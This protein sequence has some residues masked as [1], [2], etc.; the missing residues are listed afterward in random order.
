MK[1]DLFSRYELK[2]SKTNRILK[3][4]AYTIVVSSII[5]A[6]I[7]GTYLTTTE[8]GY[9]YSFYA[10]EIPHPARW[11]YAFLIILGG[12]SSSLG[13]FVLSEVLT[14]LQTI[15]YFTMNR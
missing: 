13:L 12:V 9:E 5:I 3:F 8:P 4:T 7:V 2:I 11:G 6:L 10:A 15:E 1:Q 14:R